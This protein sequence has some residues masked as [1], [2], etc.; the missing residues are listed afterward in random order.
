MSPV[1]TRLIVSLAN[2]RWLSIRLDIMGGI[3][4]FVVAVM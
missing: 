2:Q 4:V 1:K 3:L